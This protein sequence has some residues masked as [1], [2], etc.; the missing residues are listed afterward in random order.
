M[1]CAINP[2]LFD[3]DPENI[4]ASLSDFMQNMRDSDKADGQER[5][6]T[7]GEKEFENQKTVLEKGVL[8]NDATFS[9][10]A[11][12]AKER[13]FDLEEYLIVKS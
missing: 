10:I 9:E 4:F 11:K 6:Y 1:F 12:L 8:L 13:G 2:S 3:M 7:H 5:I